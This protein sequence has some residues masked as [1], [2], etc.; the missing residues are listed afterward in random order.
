MEVKRRI[1]IKK[2][3]NKTMQDQ[4]KI[5]KENYYEKLLKIR[6]AESETEPREIDNRKWWR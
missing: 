4:Q 2:E 6:K 5:I 3:N 1:T